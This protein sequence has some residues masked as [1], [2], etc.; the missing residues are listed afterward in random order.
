[1]S[2]PFLV[3]VALTVSVVVS[4]MQGAELASIHSSIQQ[5]SSLVPDYG[6]LMAWRVGESLE[7]QDGG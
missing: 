4:L 2:L 6:S 3:I 5:A 7:A 1:M